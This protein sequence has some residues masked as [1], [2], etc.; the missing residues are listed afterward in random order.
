MNPTRAVL[1]ADIV[2]STGI[3][4]SLGDNQ[5]LSV[6]NLLFAALT[7]KAVA[8]SGT[9][10]KTMGDGMVCQ[11]GAPQDAL[12]AACA[13]QAAAAEIAPRVPGQLAIKVGVNF[14]PVVLKGS[15][16]FGD[17]V[18]VCARL[19]ALANPGQIL[20]TRETS[21]ALEQPFRAQCRP[22]YP[23]KVKGRAQPVSVYE[24]TWRSDP[25]ATETSERAPAPARAGRWVL[26]LSYGGETFDVPPEG[27]ARL[28]RDRS[29]DVVVNAPRASRLHARIV[30]RERSFVIVDQSTNGTFVLTDG[31]EQELLLRREE[32]LLGERGWIGLGSPASKS[33]SHVLRYRLAKRAP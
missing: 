25:D 21:D 28:G 31:S 5:A 4:E 33:G 14:G 7:R 3:Y 32:A 2:D 13:M 12:R 10:V 26:K 1:F 30:A 24:V 20:T 18:N 27:E 11:F 22:L 15:D 16:V 17:T 29:N 8:A 6:V 9:V 19:V 23:V